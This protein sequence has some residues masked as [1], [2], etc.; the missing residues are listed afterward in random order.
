MLVVVHGLVLLV[1]L[2]LLVQGLVLQGAL[3]QAVTNGESSRRQV[4][5]HNGIVTG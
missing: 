2:L 4:T 5:C 3:Y 1:L